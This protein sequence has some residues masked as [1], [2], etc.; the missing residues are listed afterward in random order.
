VAVAGA[1]EADGE[2]VGAAAHDEPGGGGDDGATMMLASAGIVII[3]DPQG[4]APEYLLGALNGIGRAD[5]NQIRLT[6]PGISRKHAV[7]KA[8]PGG[9]AIKDLESQNGTFVNGQR[10]TEKRLSDGDTIDVGSVKF[11]FRTPWT[12]AA[13][14]TNRTSRQGQ[15]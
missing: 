4:G 2:V 15:R 9:F 3:N 14:A 12:A 11:V 10:V 13:T 5:E 1:V 6:N 7:I 8:V